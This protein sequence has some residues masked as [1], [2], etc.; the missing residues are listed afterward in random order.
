[1]T[2][3]EYELVTSGSTCNRI[4]TAEECGAAALSLGLEDIYNNYPGYIDED[5]VRENTSKFSP[6]NCWYDFI[7]GE[8][9]FNANIESTVSCSEGQGTCICKRGKHLAGRAPLL[10]LLKDYIYTNDC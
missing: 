10:A 5:Y 2:F 3:S 8:L 4:E 7:W 6:P 9:Y 1:M